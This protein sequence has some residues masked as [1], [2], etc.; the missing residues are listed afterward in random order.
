MEEI[1]NCKGYQE[2]EVITYNQKAEL[3]D[4]QLC[5]IQKLRF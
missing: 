3:N 1:V 2:G 4:A 5:D